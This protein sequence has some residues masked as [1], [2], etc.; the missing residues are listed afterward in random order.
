MWNRND[1]ESMTALGSNLVS[2]PIAVGGGGNG[3]GFAM[4]M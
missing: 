2:P 3:G 1:I 4:M